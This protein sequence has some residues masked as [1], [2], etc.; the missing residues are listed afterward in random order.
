MTP[1]ATRYFGVI[2]YHTNVM[3]YFVRSAIPAMGEEA[4]TRLEESDVRLAELGIGDFKAMLMRTPRE[5]K[6]A[7]E[8][9][10][11]DEDMLERYEDAFS[12]QYEMTGGFKNLVP[13]RGDDI[14]REDDAHFDCE[15]VY[16]IALDNQ[17]VSLFARCYMSYAQVEAE[18]RTV[19]K[20]LGVELPEDFPYQDFIG[21]IDGVIYVED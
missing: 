21:R 14:E 1:Y 19:V 12:I 6:T 7:D 8:S 9:V 5:K 20:A 13:D 10:L 11:Y 17:P 16:T 2:V 15:N 4:K 18:I 3:P